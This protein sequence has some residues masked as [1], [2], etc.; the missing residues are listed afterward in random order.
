M[1]ASAP[2]RKSPNPFGRIAVR[3]KRRHPQRP[4]KN[5]AKTLHF[6]AKDGML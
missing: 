2:T 5:S 4:Q 6:A 3:R 1:W